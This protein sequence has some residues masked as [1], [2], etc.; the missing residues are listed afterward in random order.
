MQA[1]QLESIVLDV[2]E[3][4]RLDGP[5]VSSEAIGLAVLDRLRLVDGVGYLRF[6]SVYKGFTDPGD[7]TRE[8]GLLAKSTA[9]KP[10]PVLDDVI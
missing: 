5:E 8:A 6:A 7:F 4:F 1:E 10:A 9:P 2:E 3:Q